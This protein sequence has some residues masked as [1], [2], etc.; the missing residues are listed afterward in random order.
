MEANITCGIIQK[1]NKTWRDD[2]QNLDILGY[3]PLRGKKKTLEENSH[4][5]VEFLSLRESTTKCSVIEQQLF[6]LNRSTEG[7]DCITGR[8]NFNLNQQNNDQIMVIKIQIYFILHG[9]NPKT[10]NKSNLRT[11][12]SIQI[13]DDSISLHV[14][15]ERLESHTAC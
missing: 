1:Y 7:S 12:T 8:S 15:R 9:M 3:N 5:I 6:K 13:G 14:F 10:H 4:V 11:E 2:S